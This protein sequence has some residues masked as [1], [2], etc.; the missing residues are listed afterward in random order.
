[1]NLT[2][3]TDGKKIEMKSAFRFVKL[4]L[5]GI[6]LIVLLLGSVYK[7][8]T[9]WNGVVL[10]FGKMEAIVTQPG[11]HFKLPIIDTI[12]KVNVSQIHKLEY[13][14][15]TIV[16][17]TDK[18]EPQYS[19]N[20]EEAMVI[21]DAKSNN[22]SVVL[23]NLVVRYKVD[24]P[25]NYLFKVDD[26]EGTMRLALEDVIRN[27]VQVF[28]LNEALTNK[29]AIDSE[30]LPELQKKLNEYEAGVKIVEVKTQNTM[31]L[32]EV[33]KA[34]EAVEEANQYKNGK[35]QEAIQ[36]RNTIIPQAEAE[37]TKLIEEA[38]GYKAK[39]MANA[40][41]SVAEFEALYFEYQKNPAIVKEKYYVE[42][43]KEFVANNDIVIDM[44]KGGIY[45]FYNMQNDQELKKQLVDEKNN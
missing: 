39:V 38:K 24:N 13:G 12:E 25:E 33:N 16:E 8:N 20:N 3:M 45:K 26:L 43:M 30:I 29:G 35:I 32:P 9:G 18:S 4:A 10:R 31:L 17:G 40:K 14:Y 19:D 6:L 41:A 5:L 1:M 7:L 34:Y 15:S 36:M 42:A 21:V 22:S 44:S 37:Y 2:K 23:I 28:S 11:F 27:T